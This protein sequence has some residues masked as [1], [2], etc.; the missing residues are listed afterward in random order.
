MKEKNSMNKENKILIDWLSFTSKIH[1]PESIMELL[2]MTGCKFTETYGMQGYQD[3]YIFEGISIHYNSHRNEGV[4]VEMS[5]QGCRAFETYCEYD[6]GFLYLFEY[7]KQYPDEYHITRLDVAYDDF[8]KK[9]PLKSFANSILLYNFVTRFKNRSLSVTLHPGY[10]GYTIMC[11]SVRSDILFR[12]Y[13]KAYEKGYEEGTDD[14]FDWRRFEIQMRN[15]RAFNFIKL[16][17]TENLGKLFTGLILNYLRILKPNKNDTNKRRWLMKKWFK[18]FIGDAQRISLFTK[19]DLDYNLG[20]CEDFVYGHC[21]NS[22]D[23][24]I[25][26][27]GVDTV[28]KELKERKP[29]R[30]QKYI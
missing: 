29:K 2:G 30:T 24:L 26:I 20:K 17:D 21:G 14:Y 22:I 25:E 3:R 23:A 10:S 8:N 13:D 6:D 7:F 12:I 5:G 11:G 19:C 1:S 4:W 9:I 27:K 18:E 28:V 15:D 16:L